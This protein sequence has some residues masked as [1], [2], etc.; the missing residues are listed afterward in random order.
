MN[1]P[2]VSFR[3]LAVFF[4]LFFC[5]GNLS[6]QM[7]KVIDCD[8]VCNNKVYYTLN[9]NVVTFALEPNQTKQDVRL[10]YLPKSKRAFFFREKRGDF[11]LGCE[12]WMIENQ[13]IKKIKPLLVAAY[14]KNDM[15]RMDYNSILPY[16]SI[17]QASQRIVLSFACPLIVVNPDLPSE[18]IEHT[19][20]LYALY[21]DEC[22]EIKWY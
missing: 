19:K 16:I 22:F 6:A 10:F 20:N 12:L 14:T 7:Y 21:T 5:L 8:S 18:S 13:Q 15:Q 1:E 11:S 9:K 4:C 17:I 3:Q 2:M